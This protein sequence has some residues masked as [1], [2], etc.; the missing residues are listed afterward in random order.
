MA[1]LL[2]LAGVES[3]PGPSLR[4]SGQNDNIV[5]GL[6]NVRSAIRKVASIHALLADQNLDVLA[7]IETLMWEGDPAT[8]LSDVA[9]PGYAVHH[10]PRRTGRC[11]G[12]AVVHRNSINIKFWKIPPTTIEFESQFMILSTPGKSID[13]ISI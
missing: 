6:L 13:L 7:L 1:I 11:S 9:P 12:L 4:V 2:L 3:N 5:F 10:V 8:V